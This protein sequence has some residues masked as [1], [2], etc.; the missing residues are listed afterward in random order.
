MKKSQ[1]EIMGLAVIVVLLVLAMLFVVKIV[2]I[3]R[4]S[5]VRRIYTF[6]KLAANTLDA[7]LKTNTGC[8]GIDIASLLKDCSGEKVVQCDAVDS[9]AYVDAA[10]RNILEATIT[11]LNQKYNFTARLESPYFSETV[12][13]IYSDPCAGE[14]QAPD[15]QPLRTSK[16]ILTINL[17]VCG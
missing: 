4:P 9:C 10:I 15:P 2:F 16:G 12:H 8:E 6:D 1:T 5:E 11:P 17:Y 7:L 13:S 3:D 14:R